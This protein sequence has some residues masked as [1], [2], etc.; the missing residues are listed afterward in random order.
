MPHRLDETERALERA[1]SGDNDLTAAERAALREVL[2]WWQTWKAW[3]RLGKI[4]LWG[5]ITMGAI[6]AAVRELRAS[7]WFGG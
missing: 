5:L 6:A 4:V 2:D 1:A 3:G 7:G